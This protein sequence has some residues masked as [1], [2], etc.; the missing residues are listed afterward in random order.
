MAVPAK[1]VD[2]AMAY[3]DKTVPYMDAFV[4]EWNIMRS[5]DG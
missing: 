1:E 4:D 2:V 3:N 5:V